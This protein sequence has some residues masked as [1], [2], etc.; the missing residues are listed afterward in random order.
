MWLWADPWLFFM[1]FANPNPI[2]YVRYSI[3]YSYSVIRFIVLVDYCSVNSVIYSVVTLLFWLRT[4]MESVRCGACLWHLIVIVEFWCSEHWCWWWI[5]HSRC[6]IRPLCGIRYYWP[7][8]LFSHWAS[9]IVGYWWAYVTDTVIC[10]FD[11]YWLFH[12]LKVVCYILVTIVE[13]SIWFVN[14]PSC[15]YCWWR[16][17]DCWWYTEHCSVHYAI[18]VHSGITIIPS[19]IP[20]SLCCYR[21]RCVI[22]CSLTYS[23][24]FY[25]TVLFSV[26]RCDCYLVYRCSYPDTFAVQFRAVRSL[27]CDSWP[28][29]SGDGGNTI[30]IPSLFT[31]NYTFY[32][33]FVTS[34]LHCW[35]VFPVIVWNSIDCYIGY[36]CNCD[37]CCCGYGGDPIWGYSVLHSLHLFW[38][39]YDPIVVVTCGEPHYWPLLG[40]DHC[41]S[42]RRTVIPQVM[43]DGY[44]IVVPLWF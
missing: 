27:F 31:F 1:L 34:L 5:C 36:L 37:A 20:F 2:R 7:F 22:Y 15:Y 25:I 24:L 14:C 3:E 4:L 29:R 43:V 35:T 38:W 42:L 16:F 26:C 17:G 6:S 33:T 40:C 28:G 9:G 44:S 23:F 13:H 21:Y 12:L 39:R 41:C 10:S 32:S 11:I 30:V 8:N 18:A 19:L